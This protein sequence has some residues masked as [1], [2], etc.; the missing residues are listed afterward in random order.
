MEEL[1]EF[2]YLF[3]VLS[4]LLIRIRALLYYNLLLEVE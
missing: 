1:K 3:L 2:K 4:G